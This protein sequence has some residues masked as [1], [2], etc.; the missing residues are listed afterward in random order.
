MG[1]LL[2]KRGST[3][4][5]YIQPRQPIKQ[6]TFLHTLQNGTRRFWAAANPTQPDSTRPRFNTTRFYTS[7]FLHNAAP[8]QHCFS[9]LHTNISEVGKVGRRY[10]LPTISRWIGIFSFLLSVYMENGLYC[11]WVE[12]SVTTKTHIERKNISLNE[13]IPIQ[14]DPV[15]NP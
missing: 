7:P 11:H 10:G 5:Y 9:F 6:A 13:K 12:I 3:R 1:L 4:I 2:Q 15:D 14:R 8:A